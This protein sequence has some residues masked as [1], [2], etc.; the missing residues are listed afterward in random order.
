MG[1]NYIDPSI[2]FEKDHQDMVLAILKMCGKGNDTFLDIGAH[3]G[4]WSGY[5]GQQFE[6]VIA[7]EPS[8]ENWPRFLERNKKNVNITAVNMA[9]CD[10]VGTSKIQK[11]HSLSKDPYYLG[12]R[13]Y[14]SE[15]KGCFD[16]RTTS[17]DAYLEKYGPEEPYFID[18]IKMDIEGFEPVAV[19]GM[20]K[21]IKKHEPI[22]VFEIEGRW[23][24]RASKYLN[25]PITEQY[26]IKQV[27]NLGYSA[28][29]QPDIS[30]DTI[31]V[32]RN[33]ATKV[34]D[35]ELICM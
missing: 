32:P 21:T 23:L 30:R 7:F 17:I 19:L 14:L 11:H 34:S 25:R 13:C 16:V 24:G 33:L 9:V 15:E 4:H 2:I 12:M 28:F 5:I 35:F 10:K 3:I 31:F 1:K 8:P 22:M 29:Q 18:L 27:C 6:S 20:Y 26:V